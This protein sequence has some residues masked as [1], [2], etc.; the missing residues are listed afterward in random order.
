MIESG[1][2]AAPE[3]DRREGIQSA[4]SPV[5]KE[6]ESQIRLVSLDRIPPCPTQPRV[7]FSVPFW[8][9]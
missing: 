1:L 7:N 5:A 9:S 8:L 6:Q 2:A 4:P 3:V